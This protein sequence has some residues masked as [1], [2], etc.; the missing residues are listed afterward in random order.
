ML[1]PYDQ[2]DLTGKINHFEVIKKLRLEINVRADRDG[3]RWSTI[4]TIHYGYW[5]YGVT[6]EAAIEEYLK[7]NCLVDEVVCT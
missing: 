4:S 5:A 7:K 3:I 6:L 2:R 1:E